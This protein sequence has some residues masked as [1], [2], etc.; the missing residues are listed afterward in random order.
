[1][2][3]RSHSAAQSTELQEEDTEQEEVETYTSADNTRQQQQ[4]GGD[5]AG[6][7]DSSFD[8]NEEAFLF[9]SRLPPLHLC[10]PAGR[11]AALP[12]KAA[13]CPPC[14][15]VL[16]LDE[17]LVHSSLDAGSGVAASGPHDFAFPVQFE[18]ALH[19]VYVRKR[20][21]LQVRL[22]LSGIPPWR[23]RRRARKH[24]AARALFWEQALS[25][26]PILTHFMCCAGVPGT[27][28]LPV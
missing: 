2:A 20:P 23:G 7:D 8:D 26:P 9:I 22:C 21:G 12:P 1:M 10:T 28:E 5:A 3:P 11:E 16:D 17:T 24:W 18:D 4:G 19:T 14:T 13:G 6:Q 25:S 15:L 27:R